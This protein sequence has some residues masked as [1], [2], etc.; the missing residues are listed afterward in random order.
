MT[1]EKNSLTKLTELY[2]Q[3]GEDNYLSPLGSADEEILRKDITHVQF[4]WLK[5]FI[6]IWEKAEEVEDFINEQTKGNKNRE[7]A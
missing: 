4:N 3:W 2:K 7:V 5:N 6:D 1:T